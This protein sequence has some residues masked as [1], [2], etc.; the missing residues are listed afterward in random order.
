MNNNKLRIS[1]DWKASTLALLLLPGLITLGYWQL[2]RAEEKRA[3]KALFEVRA[4][5]PAKSIKQLSIGNNDS[6]EHLRYQPVRLTGHYLNN[7]NILLD[8]KVFHGRFGYEILTA[9]N[10]N[11][12]DDI[13]WVNRGW[14]AGDSSRRSMPIIPAIEAE[15]VMLEAEVYVPHSEM[16]VLG[17]Q[18][19]PVLVSNKPLLLQQLNISL[20]AQQMPGKTFPLSVRLKEQSPGVLER[21]WMVVNVQPEKHTAYAFQW[22][23]MAGMLLIIALLANTNI[24]QWLKLRQQ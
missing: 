17:E 7:F 22:F 10:V 4:Q 16:M 9:F 14:L 21:N 11:H 2:D 15:S 19:R 8:N 13:V 24:W 1:L 18:V 23:S 5:S 6:R 12:S 20:I 3:L